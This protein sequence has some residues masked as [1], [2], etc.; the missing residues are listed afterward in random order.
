MAK[1]NREYNLTNREKQITDLLAKGKT[2][3]AVGNELDISEQTVKNHRTN[4]YQKLRVHNGIEAIAR[5]YAD[6][7]LI[8]E[9]HTD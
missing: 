7:R 4:I 9:P 6:R 8:D 3:K 5:I 2:S 1:M